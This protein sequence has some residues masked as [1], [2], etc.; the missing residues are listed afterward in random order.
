[1][2]FTVFIG[3]TPSKVRNDMN[4]HPN[5]V[6]RQTKS[7]SINFNYGQKSNQKRS[8]MDGDRRDKK[9]NLQIASEVNM[10]AERGK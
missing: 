10:Q 6:S 5:I 1:M 8:H 7:K 4:D 3:P 2:V 9:C